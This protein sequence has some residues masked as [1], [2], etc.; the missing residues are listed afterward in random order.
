MPTWLRRTRAALTLGLAWAITWAPVGVLVSFVVDPDGSMDEPWLLMFG[1]PGFLGG[2]LFSALLALAERRRS[3]RELSLPRVA[4]WGA[5]A[6]L[7]VANLPFVLGSP[8]SALPLWLLYGIVAG[9]ITTLCAS[10]AAGTVAI[11]RRA[12]SPELPPADVST[13]QRLG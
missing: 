10:S 1:I 13:A 2:V 5:V 12:R 3:V 8:S 11:A 9:S 6:G 7:T 4:G